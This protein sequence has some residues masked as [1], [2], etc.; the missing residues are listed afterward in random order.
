MDLFAEMIFIHGFVHGNPHPGNVL[1][2]P[3]GHNDFCMGK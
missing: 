2:C 1:V 3:Q